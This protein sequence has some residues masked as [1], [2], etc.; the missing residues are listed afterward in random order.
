MIDPLEEAGLSDES[1]SAMRIVNL[2][3]GGV[4]TTR[5]ELGRLTGLG[6][7]SSPSGWIAPFNWG[8]S[9]NSTASRRQPVA[10]RG[11]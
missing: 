1:N 4:A 2:V 7:A 6:E 10:R 8:C 5:P 11:V 3:R 9:K